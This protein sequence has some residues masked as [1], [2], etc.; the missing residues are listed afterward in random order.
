MAIV[1]DDQ[2]GSLNT[3]TPKVILVEVTPNPTARASSTNVVG[4]VG[5]F[6]RGA[7][8][9]IYNVTSLNELERKLGGYLDGY[10]GYLFTKD[11][12]DANGSVAKIVRVTSS[13]TAYATGAIYSDAGATGLVATFTADTVGT[14]GNYI[15]VDVTASTVTGYVDLVVRNTKTSEVRRYTKTTFTSTSDTRYIVTLVNADPSKFFTLSVASNSSNPYAT[16]T[17]L[18]GGSNGASTGS[19][20]SD[21]AYVG[22]ESGGT[23]TGIQAFKASSAEDVSIVLSCRNTDTIN[24]ALITHVS[25]INLSPR[26]TIITFA[27]GTDVDTA[28]GK[29]ATLDSDKVKVTFPY[30]YVEN[31]FTGVLELHNPVAFDGANDT[32]LSYHQSA[33]QTVYPATVRDIEFDLSVGDIN[34]LTAKRINPI[35]LKVGRGF[36]RSSDYTTSSNPS[37]SQNVV[38]KAKDYFARTFYDLLQFYLSK[39]ITVQLWKDIKDALEAFLRLEEGAGRIGNSQGGK[40]FGVKIDAENNPT[41]IV[42]L[43]KIIALVEISLLAPADII[44]VFLDAQQDKTIVG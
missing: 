6:I 44:Q 27:S 20:L 22:T 26:R 38:R 37:L 23:R 25:D 11:F 5:Q 2:I 9:K 17:T 29:M 36:I 40:A 3:S 7:T 21:T 8:N 18:S 1:R 16:S 39:P 31:P 34:S 19:S 43:N 28:I 33:S 14:W 30:V 24:S 32:V 35:V 12:F 15:T 10:D 13:G 4:I 42:K 41:D